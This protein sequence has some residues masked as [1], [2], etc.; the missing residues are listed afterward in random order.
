[1]FS[2]S[3]LLYHSLCHNPVFAYFS[4]SSVQLQG[5]NFHGTWGFC[6]KKAVQT[7]SNESRFE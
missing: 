1:M 3:F 4:Y 6:K 5:C 7:V 2:I